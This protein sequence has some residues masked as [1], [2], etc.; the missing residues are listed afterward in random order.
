[1][2]FLV[3]GGAGF[4]GSHL[5]EAL[6]VAG[7]RVTALDDLSTG[8][9]LNIQGVMANPRFKFVQGSVCH[10][11][12]LA[13]LVE[14]CDAIFHLAAAVGVQLIVQRPVHTI[15]TNIHGTEVVLELANKFRKRILITSTSEVYGKSTKIPFQEDDD[16]LLGSTRFSRWSYACSKMVDE[17]LALAYHVEF[18]LEVIICRPFNT[19]GPRQV[20]DFGM[21][22]P[23]FVRSA[24]ESKPVEVFGTGAQRRCFCNVSDLV[25]ALIRL[26]ECR[27]AAGEVVNIGNTESTTIKALAEKIISLTGSK[28]ELRF[29]SHREAYGRPVED[30][31]DRSPDISKAARLIGFKP[32]IS[33]E[34]TLRQIVEYETR[35]A[36]GA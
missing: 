32:S 22:V 1:M 13:T 3:T 27:G 4:I 33:L 21:V 18:G 30:M 23:R 17:F 12:T 35:T 10:E 14:G 9:R 31:L 36:P 5:V 6:L 24:L 19:I 34:Q 25:S 29:L 20:G 11:N 26:M 15:S 28:S 7:H 8:S 2:N 16:I